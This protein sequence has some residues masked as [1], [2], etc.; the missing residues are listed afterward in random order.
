MNAGPAIKLTAHP[1]KSGWR[2]EHVQMLGTIML[3]NIVD[4]LDNQLLPL[5]VGVISAEW[6]HSP[7]M[8]SGAVSAGFL[9]A[10]L[11]T[12]I[13]GW[14]GDRW[15]RKPAILSGM[16]VF[17]LLTLAMAWC[18]TTGQLTVAR[19]IAGIG[20]GTCIPPM[21]ALVTESV[22][23]EKRGTAVALT[24]LSMPLGLTLAGVVIPRLNDTMGWKTSFVVC[25]LAV[26]AVAALALA[27]LRERP[28]PDQPKSPQHPLAKPPSAISSFLSGLTVPTV[29]ALMGAIFLV[30]V[31]MS[32]ALSW[33]P[34]FSV[35]RGITQ[36]TAG[37]AISFWSLSGMA[38]TLIAGWAV[39][40]FGSTTAARLIV[41]GFAA[42]SLASAALLAIIGASAF[43][44][45]FAASL[46]GLFASGAITVLYA[47]AAE[48]F[49]QTMRAQGLAAV[50]L[51]GK[52]GG[53]A[54]GGSG[55]ILL[56][57]PTL[58]GFFAV[59]GAVTLAAFS[60]LLTAG[61]KRPQ[62]H[63]GQVL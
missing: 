49:P 51:A 12:P 47:A 63:L 6:G 16:L 57:L 1:A 17:G 13:G 55:L 22:P 15:G 30:Y 59:L 21:L 8:F 41:A 10:A 37:Q 2:W 36:I 32:A 53:V 20:L 18:D 38:G 48:Q 7:A 39:N 27:T 5:S 42:G 45:Y 11:G 19:L 29:L 33:L 60:C 35:S 34:T 40:R 28:R 43:T 3:I 61:R 26:F 23:P 9:G 24:M 46:T 44:L 25:S 54:G 50:T 56:A 31:A 4:G 58:A 52:A 14:L 62:S